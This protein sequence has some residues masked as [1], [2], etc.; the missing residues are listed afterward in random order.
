MTTSSTA[1]TKVMRALLAF[2]GQFRP[3]DLFAHLQSIAGG[4]RSSVKLH[5]VEN[6]VRLMADEGDLSR[7]G[8]GLYQ[9]CGPFRDR[10][11]IKAGR[12]KGATATQLGFRD[13]T[14]LSAIKAGG[15]LGMRAGAI[16]NAV[17]PSLA[18][19]DVSNGLQA[20]KRKNLVAVDVNHLWSAVVSPMSCHTTATITKD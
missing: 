8:H 16:H 5:D 4:G 3:R 20:M 2:D 12:P 10:T 14:I 9:T 11:G 1:R 18:Y 17:A 13:R 15:L 19:H 7:L 6:L